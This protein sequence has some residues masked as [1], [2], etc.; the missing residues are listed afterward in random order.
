MILRT[1][2]HFFWEKVFFFKLTKHYESVLK[3]I[4]I[5]VLYKTQ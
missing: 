2:E 1:C 4:N 3:G 5:E